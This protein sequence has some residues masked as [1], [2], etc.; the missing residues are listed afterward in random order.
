MKL[1]MFLPYERFVIKTHLDPNSVL[2]KLETVAETTSR[3]SLFSTE[4]RK[5]YWGKFKDNRFEINRRI[6]FRNSFLPV[7]KGRVNL[8]VTGS[9]IMVTMHLEII[10]IVFL[11]IWFG[12]IIYSFPRLISELITVIQSGDFANVNSMGFALPLGLL[13]FGYLLTMIAFKYEAINSKTFLT[14]LLEAKQI[15]ELGL[16]ETELN[17]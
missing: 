1:M 7:I 16:F 8:D 4:E 9:I 13:L 11:C 5:P 10:V 14:D 2:S 12:G 6:H 17:T 3:F 15:I